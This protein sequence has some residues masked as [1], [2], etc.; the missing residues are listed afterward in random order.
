[1]SGAWSLRFWRLTLG[2]LLA[3]LVSAVVVWAFA[4]EPLTFRDPHTGQTGSEWEEISTVHFD[5]SY[6]LAL[7]AGFSITDSIMLQVWD[8]LVDSEQIGPGDAISYTN[9]VGG[10]FYSSP[11]PADVCEGPPLFY[12]NVIWPLWDSMQDPNSCVTSRFGPYSPFFHFPHNDADELG[13]L[14]N[15]AWGIT[16]TLVAYEAYAW[17]GPTDFTVMDA[18]CLYTRTVAITTGIQAGSLEAFATYL[19]SLADYYSHRECIA[20]MDDLGQ[21]WA[22][23]TLV[24]VPECNYNPLN[25]RPDDVHGREFYTYTDALRTDEAIRHIYGELVARSL[26]GEG[27]YFPVGL[28][29]PISGGE[30]LSDMLYSFVHTWD[31]AHPGERRTQADRI[32]DAILAMRAPLHRLYLPMLQAD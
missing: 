6:A 26:Q 7:A 3:V 32:A 28:N 12:S 10:A 8:Q 23:H 18:R 24:G 15:W 5:L 1:M 14:Y 16:D 19:H 25:P 27:L 17:G 29:T 9:C 30:T 31:F 20:A 22:T 21:P 2:V 13:A 4:E 11:D